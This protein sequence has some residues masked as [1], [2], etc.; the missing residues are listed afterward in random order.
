[1]PEIVQDGESGFLFEPGSINELATLLKKAAEMDEIEYQRM[2]MSA[3]RF[4]N[5]NFE[6][7]RHYQQLIKIYTETIQA[8]NN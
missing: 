7:E 6:P 8:F 5:K 4:A 3:R 2:S 1:M